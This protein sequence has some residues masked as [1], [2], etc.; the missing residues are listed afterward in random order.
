MDLSAGEGSENRVNETG[1][2]SIVLESLLIVIIV[3]HR[4]RMSMQIVCMM[5]Q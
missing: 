2:W 5:T 3:R 1:I 4:H